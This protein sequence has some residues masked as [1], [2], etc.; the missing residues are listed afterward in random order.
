MNVPYLHGSVLITGR[1]D[2][3]WKLLEN[4]GL[5]KSHVITI[6]LKRNRYITDKH[7]AAIARSA[8]GGVDKCDELSNWV[9]KSAS[10]GLRDVD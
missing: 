6:P 3:E 5:R 9:G 2:L 4:E 8:F 10:V 1:Y 7:C